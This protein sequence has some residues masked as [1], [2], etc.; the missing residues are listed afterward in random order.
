[1]PRDAGRAVARGL[2]LPV[3]A[4]PGAGMW[5]ALGA[6]Q[7][8][9]LA[10]ALGSAGDGAVNQLA[11]LWHHSV[12]LCLSQPLAMPLVLLPKCCLLPQQAEGCGCW[13]SL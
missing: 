3:G 13:M 11:L 8:R 4:R 7:G 5:A 10:G 9:P 2:L 1:M 6:G 12:P